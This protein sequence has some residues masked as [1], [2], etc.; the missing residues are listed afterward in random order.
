MTELE[1]Q[2]VWDL[3]YSQWPKDAVM[4]AFS[5][6]KGGG[7][8]GYV[9]TGPQSLRQWV[10]YNDRMEHNSYVQLNPTKR[11]SGQRVSGDDITH[12]S[13][14]MVDIDPIAP[15][16]NLDLATSFVEGFMRNYFGLQHYDPTIIFSGRGQQ[17]WFALEPYDLSQ[18]IMLMKEP[19]PRNWG[20]FDNLSLDRPVETVEVTLREAAPR[21][22][23]YWLNILKAR[24]EQWDQARATAGLPTSGCT[25]D[26]SVS[27]L[28]RVMRM[29][30][31]INY[32]TGMLALILQEGS[33][34]TGL[35]DKLVR[36]APYKLWQEP[37]VIEG[38]EPTEG[39]FWGNFLPHMKVGGRIYLTEGA[40]EG[41]RHKAATAALLS[42]K[43]LGCGREQ[44][45]AALL[46]G[47]KLCSPPLDPREI[48]PMIE[49]HYR[50][51]A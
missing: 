13:W 40:S 23:S 11:R 43:E 37:E 48:M 46:F 15:D 42:L 33:R 6:S 35:A 10:A 24:M 2:E 38:F 19:P 17:L 5:R 28:P 14:F 41:G 32:K 12:W 31:T 9:P 8:L 26:T 47:A 20:G 34:H 1:A 21:A 51:V 3:M 27:D 30:Y 25:I 16:P 44:A 18:R 4:R 49:R 45:R 39:T 50:R 36:Y 7:V 29:P 22:M